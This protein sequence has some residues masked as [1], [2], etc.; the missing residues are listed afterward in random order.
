MFES[1]LFWL[2]FPLVGV[3]YYLGFKTSSKSHLY[4]LSFVSLGFLAAQD[5]L[6]TAFL[7]LF[8]V[9]TFFCAQLIQQSPPTQSRWL[10]ALPIAL[11]IAN[12]VLTKSGFGWALFG[13]SFYT[14][15][16]ISYLVDVKRGH[17]QPTSDY[18][19]FFTSVS[20]FLYL[21]A[22]P[23]TRPREMMPRF[24]NPTP[25]T[26]DIARLALIRIL[27]GL[28]KKN[29]GDIV[30]QNVTEAFDS[31]SLTTWGTWIAAANLTAQYYLDFSGYTDVAI[32]LGALLGIRLPENFHLPFLATSVADH[33]RRWHITLAEWFR[34]YVFTPLCFFPLPKRMNGF[35]PSEGR[36]AFGVLTSMTLIGLWHGI[37]L[38]NLLWGFYNGFFI[39]L[40]A[41]LGRFTKGSLLDRR[42]V[43]IAV[44]FYVL[45]LGRI[46][47]RAPNLQSAVTMIVTMHSPTA[48]DGWNFWSFWRLALATLAIVLP[49]QIDYLILHKREAL[50]K[51]SIAW[52]VCLIFAFLVLIF[53]S[54]PGSFIYQG[55]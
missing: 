3:I 41:P 1:V 33:W 17:I 43:K 40:S 20:S 8:S 4:W 23:V 45:L 10:V 27:W 21:T 18:P 48:N 34:D 31:A 36:L 44:T 39:L 46:L 9:I 16:M 32:G 15:P 24:L 12:I 42:T 47:T 38:N 25:L 19:A 35:I 29:V 37:N 54:A 51:P 26:M 2:I 52:A 14:F 53:R 55:F 7:I 30:G 50:S 5:P 28:A 22:G 49:H 13:L 6:S 11:M